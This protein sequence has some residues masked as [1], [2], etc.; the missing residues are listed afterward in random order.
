MRMPHSVVHAPS[1]PRRR[2]RN[3]RSPG[4]TSPL[5]TT[6]DPPDAVQT[7]EAPASAAVIPTSAD[8]TDEIRRLAALL[9]V[10]QALSGTLNLRAALQ[11]VLEILERSHGVLR[12]ALTLLDP[13]AGHLYIEASSGI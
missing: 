11:R 4:M 2:R 12:S 7:I 5:R 8:P 13:E 6:E 9:D 3:R 10:S 1:P